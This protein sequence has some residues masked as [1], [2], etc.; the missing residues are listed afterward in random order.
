M[1]TFP[2]TALVHTTDGRTLVTTDPDAR[3]LR[4]WA[5]GS[6]A[7]GYDLSVVGSLLPVRL[8]VEDIAEFEL[9]AS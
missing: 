7:W 6:S 1:L 2:V 8:Y 4:K 5:D 9:I 3:F